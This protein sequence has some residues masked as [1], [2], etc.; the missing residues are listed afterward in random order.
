[1]KTLYVDSDLNY[2]KEQLDNSVNNQE[3]KENKD[4]SN[5]V[6]GEFKEGKKLASYLA[7]I[8]S[9]PQESAAVFDQ[10]NGVR[11]I[12]ISPDGKHLVRKTELSR[13]RFF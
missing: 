6:G 13:K 10:R 1:M 8:F 5:K 4:T 2:I 12:R 7:C 3:N 9:F 11:C